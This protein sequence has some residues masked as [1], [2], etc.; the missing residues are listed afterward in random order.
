M[1]QFVCVNNKNSFC[2]DSVGNFYGVRRHELHHIDH[3]MQAG[4]GYFICKKC[5]IQTYCKDC[6]DETTIY[7]QEMS[8]EL[9]SND[10]KT[11]LVILN[12]L[13]VLNNDFN[14]KTSLAIFNKT[15]LDKP[16]SI[17]YKYDFIYPEHVYVKCP[18]CKS[19]YFVK[20]QYAELKD[21]YN[22]EDEFGHEEI[23]IYDRYSLKSKE[24]LHTA[25]GRISRRCSIL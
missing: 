7:S 8:F 23:F 13:F 16:K 25:G 11:L 18:L 20:Y 1:Q 17:M 10:K 3:I 6:R 21:I 24:R 14:L 4:E 2:H 12:E 5:C 15:S 19:K 22:I 9:V